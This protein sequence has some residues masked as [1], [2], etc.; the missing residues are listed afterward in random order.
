[1]VRFVV[2]L[3]FFFFRKANVIFMFQINFRI[4]FRINKGNFFYIASLI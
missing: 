4:N 1:M 3:F 2:G